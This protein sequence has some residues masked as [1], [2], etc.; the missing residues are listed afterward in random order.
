MAVNVTKK[1]RGAG[2]AEVDTHQH[3]TVIDVGDGHLYVRDGSGTIA[4]YAPDTW[5]KAE[6]E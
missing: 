6:V 4:I 2:R 3:G 1:P 5:V